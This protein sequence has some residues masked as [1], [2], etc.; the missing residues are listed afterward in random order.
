MAAV[1]EGEGVCP[2]KE[3][4]RVRPGNERHT[5]G[6]ETI[7]GGS[8]GVD[9]VEINEALRH[10]KRQVWLVEADRRENL[11][12]LLAARRCLLVGGECR[13]CLVFD[14][15]IRERVC[16]L[17]GGGHGVVARHVRTVTMRLGVQG[18]GVAAFFRALEVGLRPRKRVTAAG[19]SGLLASAR[20]VKDLAHA[21]R[22]VAVLSKVLRHGDKIAAHLAE[23][24]GE[25]VD[26]R[27]LDA[28]AGQERGARRAA[29]R[30]LHVAATERVPSQEGTWLDAKP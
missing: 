25:K 5:V 1:A 14:L 9:W 21:A 24:L 27:R 29:D 10:N 20:R 17:L 3:L 22:G 16:C 13:D 19:R 8:D 15:R 12:R 26:P 4:P 7:R 28:T 11:A 23:V 18:A 2:R 6:R 30:L